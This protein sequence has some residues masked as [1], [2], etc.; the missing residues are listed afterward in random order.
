VKRTGKPDDFLAFA[1]LSVII[2]AVDIPEGRQTPVENRQPSS[3]QAVLITSI[4][5]VLVGGVGLVLLFNLTVPTLGPRW[6]LFF[7]VTLAASGLALP[8]AYFLNLRFPGSQPAG[9][10]VLMREALFFGIY[11]DVLIWLRFGKVLNFAIGVFLLVGFA[12]IE[13]LVR[14]RENSRFHPGSEEE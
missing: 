5:F 2:E 4:I 11:V 3:F 6:L 12:L 13:L 9:T 14:W 8:V 7:L 1:P 10:N